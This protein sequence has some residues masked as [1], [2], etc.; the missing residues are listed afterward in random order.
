MVLISNFHTHNNYCDGNN[1]VEEMI[2]SA[3]DK[4][5]KYIGISSHAP[6]PDE[7]SWTMNENE[8]QGYLSEIRFL[9]EKYKK[10]INVFAGLEID[11][12]KD[13]GLN[14]VA[15]PYMKN[16]D[17]YIGSVHS[18]NKNKNGLYCFVDDSNESFTQGIKELYNGDIK[19]AVKDYYNNI[20][21]LVK[22]YNPDILGHIDIIKK[23]NVDN[24][25]FNEDESWYKEI[26]LDTL[27]CIKCSNTIVE[28]NTGGIPRYGKHA[29][30]PSIYILENIL[31]M[32]I[33]I[34][35]NG[36][37]HHIDNI[38][39]YYDEIKGIIESIGFE[40]IRVLTNK[41]WIDADL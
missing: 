38:N 13:V 17:Y 34:T 22:G 5:I 28:I 19:S 3:I 14:P 7:E 6:I 40:K 24:I 12:F 21:D 27:H 30:Y 35:V 10:H 9:K 29:L 25:Y 4:G 39:Y 37:S 11:Y 18:F 36:D 15:I 41:G 32:G 16:L 1:T 8:V 33:P 23:N 26:I 31:R 20:K 2:V